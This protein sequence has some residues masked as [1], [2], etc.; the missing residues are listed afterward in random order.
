MTEKRSAEQKSKNW[1]I[2]S[3]NSTLSD[4]SDKAPL[5]PDWILACFCTLCQAARGK[6]QSDLTSPVFNVLCFSPCGSYSFVR[7]AYNIAG[8]GLSDCL[9]GFFCCVCASRQLFHEGNTRGC[10]AGKFGQ[11]SHSWSSPLCGFGDFQ[12]FL[13]ALCCPCLVTHETRQTLQFRSEE[14]WF[15][16]LCLLPTSMYGQTRNTFGIAPECCHALCDDVVVALLCC[17]CA[18]ARARREAAYQNT[19]HATSAAGGIMLHDQA[20]VEQHGVYALKKLGVLGKR[21]EIE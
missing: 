8:D 17:P 1:H 18:V 2:G 7:E 4:C 9:V 11:R 6:A 16:R 12:E 19:L 21:A 5:I 14:K 3:W 15:D 10:T 13:N 20:K